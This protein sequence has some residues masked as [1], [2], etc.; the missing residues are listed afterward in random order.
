[1]N[2]IGTALPSASGT[3]YSGKDGKK[4]AAEHAVTASF[5]DTLANEKDAAAKTDRLIMSPAAASGIAVKSS[6]ADMSMTEYQLYINSKISKIMS[7]SHQRG[8]YTAVFIS[9]E[10]Y[11]A[12]KNDPEYEKW[13][14]DLIKQ[15]SYQNGFMHGR[16]EKHYSAHFVGASKEET[17]SEYW[18]DIPTT[19]VTVEERRAMERKRF[20]ALQKYR[21]QKLA[22]YRKALRENSIKKAELEEEHIKGIFRDHLYE[23]KNICAAS[24][25]STMLLFRT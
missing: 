14:L 10:G 25:V 19:T 17:H 18:S 4:S 1:M 9:D 16:D 21:T 15:S 8:G 20:Y 23:K 6:A 3:A 7:G 12:M 2:I 22:R 13:V 5:A 11:A 24:H